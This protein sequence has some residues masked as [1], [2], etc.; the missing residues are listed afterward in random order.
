MTKGSGD[1]GKWLW[2]V[3]T[4]GSGNLGSSEFGKRR[5]RELVTFGSGS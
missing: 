5:L 2:E 1:L 4:D 3:V